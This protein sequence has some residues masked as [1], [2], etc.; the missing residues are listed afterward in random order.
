[1]EIM[2][3]LEALRALDSIHSAEKAMF[4][5]EIRLKHAR[6]RI[7]FQ[8][9]MGLIRQVDTNNIEL[10][11]ATQDF[12]NEEQREIDSV[13]DFYGVPNVKAIRGKAARKIRRLL[14]DDTCSLLGDRVNKKT[15]HLET[16]PKNKN[17]YWLVD[18]KSAVDFLPMWDKIFAKLLGVG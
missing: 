1:M 6:E 17:I 4:S 15:D 3:S 10:E 5:E 9:K 11:D 2:D 16:D 14:G 13:L 18:T 7:E 12:T 8:Q